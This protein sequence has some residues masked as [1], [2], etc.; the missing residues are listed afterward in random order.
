MKNFKKLIA[1]TCVAAMLVPTVAFADDVLPT[2]SPSYSGDS[3]VENDNSGV[4]EYTSVVLPTIDED[5][6]TYDFK[7][8]RDDLLKEYDK[9]NE[10]DL[11][12]Q[13]IYFNAEKT[14]AT[15]ALTGSGTKLYKLSIVED[16]AL[17]KLTSVLVKSGTG[18]TGAEMAT[19]LFGDAGNT[20]KF[21]AWSPK[22]TT[23]NGKGD[24]V[25]IT[26]DT[27]N[28][29]IDVTVDD[30]DSPTAITAIAVKNDNL[31]GSVIWDGKIYV[32]T[33]EEI[34]TDNNVGY[35]NTVK[36][37]GITAEDA[38]EGLFVS[39]DADSVPPTALQVSDYTYTAATRHFTSTTDIATIENKSTHPVAVSVQ[40]TVEAD[41]LTFSEDGVYTSDTNA[42]IYVAVQEAGN[43]TNKA[44]VE[45]GKA[46]A[47]YILDRTTPNGESNLIKFQGGITEGSATGSHSY[48]TYEKPNVV[49]D[50][51][52][53]S[54]TASANQEEGSDAAWDAYIEALTAENSEIEKPSIS[55]VYTIV[56]VE[57]GEAENTYV[58]EDNNVYTVTA[59][60]NW[61]TGFE[62]GCEHTYDNY[63]DTECND[64]GATRDG[65]A[66]SL[67]FSLSSDKS[68]SYI[69]VGS[70]ATL[71]E[72]NFYDA[73][74]YANDNSVDKL[75]TI[76]TSKFTVSTSGN[77]A[78]TN[79]ALKEAITTPGDY[80]VEIKTATKTYI[81]IYT[82]PES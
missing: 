28:N 45:N 76:E 62:V 6:D 31:S 70:G 72:V 60:D 68:K 26:A 9:V 18:A 48:Y 33:Y 16:V 22:S 1:L 36:E 77:A 69:T 79:T 3:V 41:G 57:D 38:G 64:C 14:A 59:S 54:I 13:G 56:K 55:V 46:T 43:A 30:V 21:Y 63:K 73:K 2:E 27:I 5:G 7:I 75:G 39:T 78:I 15:I 44:A 19:A 17:A 4:P 20:Y 37:Y 35:A 51:V 67:T 61:V 29:Y 40:V 12:A 71:T 65:I 10:Y 52:S 66:N 42:S 58:D 74:A 47:Y 25:E 81:V 34:T 80:V 24:F 82:R 49:G 53:F 23:T 50:S 8:D 11:S 32:E